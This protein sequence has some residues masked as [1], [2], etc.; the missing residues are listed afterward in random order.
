MAKK[1]SRKLTTEEALEQL[2]GRKAAKRIRQLA[3]QLTASEI[4]SRESR[5]ASA[6][7]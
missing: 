3:E 6:T 1:K 7:A 4:S 2:L 5:R